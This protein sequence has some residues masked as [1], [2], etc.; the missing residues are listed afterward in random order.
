MFALFLF[1]EV[2]VK[3]ILTLLE[4]LTWHWFVASYVGFFHIHSSDVVKNLRFEDKDF[5]LKDMDL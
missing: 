5:R 1:F 4:W 2:S 3:L